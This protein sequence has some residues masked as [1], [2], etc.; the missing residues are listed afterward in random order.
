MVSSITIRLD[1]KYARTD[2]DV[3]VRFEK[4]LPFWA[5]NKRDYD[6]TVEKIKK[7]LEGL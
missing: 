5:E 1:S 4:N 3:T 6:E 7:F 2:G